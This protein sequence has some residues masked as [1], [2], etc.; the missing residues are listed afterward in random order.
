MAVSSGSRSRSGEGRRARR[1]EDSPR[2]GLCGN[3]L[4]HQ[5]AEY[6]AYELPTIV[7]RCDK[8]DLPALE[9]Q[10]RHVFEVYGKQL[11]FTPSKNIYHDAYLLMKAIR[12]FVGDMEIELIGEDGSEKSELVAFKVDTDFNVSNIY[13]MPVK[14]LEVVNSELRQILLDF[15]SF[16]LRFSPFSLPTESYEMCLA[17]GVDVDTEKYEEDR[18]GYSDEF[19]EQA[20][21]Y[22]LGDL[23][24]IFMQMRAKVKDYINKGCV[25]ELAKDV[26]RGIEAYSGPSLYQ[27]PD[28]ESRSVKN[29]FALIKEGIELNIEDNITDY[30]LLI[31]R[32][33]LGDQNL[34][35]EG[36]HSDNIPLLGYQ[37]VFCYAEDDVVQ[38]M[39]EMYNEL[40][41]G[42]DM[43]TLI[44]LRRLSRLKE[45]IVFGDYPKRYNDWLEKIYDSIYG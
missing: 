12:G 13:L 18:S 27:L 41:G 17:M 38:S 43:P 40:H 16:L 10:A 15:F 42:G 20:D 2:Q 23:H 4:T 33:E 24:E 14:I 5:F 44:Q 7:G 6:H 45:P 30:E 21:R 9:T 37:F 3:F 25:M 36:G 1:E 34:Y 28:G 11:E 39:T 26:E 32:M 29:L 35:R 31:H 19:N 8:I 22:V